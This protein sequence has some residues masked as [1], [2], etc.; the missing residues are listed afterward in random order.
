MHRRSR[1]TKPCRICKSEE[2]PYVECP[3]PLESPRVCQRI[4]ESLSDFHYRLRTNE[5]ARLRAQATQADPVRREALNSRVRD[6]YGGRPESRKESAR[7]RYA[8]NR[9]RLDELKE[10]PCIDCKNTFPPECMDFDHLPGTEKVA[11]VGA[12]I[13]SSIAE[14][15]KCDLVCAN[16]HRIRTTFRKRQNMKSR[17]QA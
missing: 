8:K 11:G 10:A 12:M 17:R 16:C 4:G 14:I 1:A 3:V 9:A 6:W 2:H 5:V 7:K 13:T 15:S